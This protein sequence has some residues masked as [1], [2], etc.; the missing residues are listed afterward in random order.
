MKCPCLTCSERD[1]DK[2]RPVCIECDR[3]IAYSDY[4]GHPS[5][6]VPVEMHVR[7][8][9]PARSTAN[10]NNIARN[11]TQT[12]PASRPDAQKIKTEEKPMAP[13]PIIKTKICS[14]CKGEHPADLE[15]FYKKKSSADGL[16]C[17]CKKCAIEKQKQY[18]Q[19]YRDKKKSA[20]ARK[21]A[22]KPAGAVAD[23]V[24]P[25]PKKSSRDSAAPENVISLDFSNHPDIL[26][27]LKESAEAD[28][29][30]PDMQAIAII[31]RALNGQYANAEASSRSL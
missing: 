6:S 24:R 10:P 25:A 3:R 23:P 28:L 8:V 14:I 12:A 27:G 22:R 15:H 2:T 18:D 31:R 9:A 5:S 1:G 30:T 13:E 29:R 4:L 11:E 7:H 17:W 20:R 26:N 16:D 19:R 21:A